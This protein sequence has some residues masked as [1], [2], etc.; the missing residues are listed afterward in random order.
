L[1]NEIELKSVVTDADA[2]RQALDE[3]GAVLRFHGMMRDRRLDRGGELSARDEV[4]RVR[5]WIDEDGGH[6]LAETAWKGKT[7]VNP[8]GYKQ[9][10]EV[11][12]TVADGTAA[13]RLLTALGYNPVE[14]IDRY[15]EVFELEGTVA[16]IEWFPRMDTLVEIEGEPE[17]IES[18]IVLIGLDRQGCVADSLASFSRRYEERTG[19]PAILAEDMLAGAPPT[20]LQR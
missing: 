6:P 18:L 3:A 9:R 20:W 10:E 4:L 8:E 2:L 1:A 11:E 12:F 14:V 15:V 7:S 5:T 19:E 17:G 13:L 16:R